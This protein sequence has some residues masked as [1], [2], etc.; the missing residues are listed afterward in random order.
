MIGI[1]CPYCGAANIEAAARDARSFICT[2]CGKAV[3]PPTRS[4]SALPGHEVVP[5]PNR[6]ASAPTPPP[7]SE[8]WSDGPPAESANRWSEVPPLGH[9]DSSP[10]LSVSQTSLLPNE[11]AEPPLVRPARSPLVWLIV[12]LLAFSAALVGVIVLARSL[13]PWL[14]A[15]HEA[16][17]RKSVEYWLPRLENGSAEERAEAAKAIVGLGPPA[18]V[19]A[20]EKVSHDPE[21]D[22]DFAFVTDAIH[23][24]AAVGPDAVF[25]L[26]AALR[27]PEPRVR[28]AAANVVQE[29]GPAG[30]AT[31]PE[32]LAARDDQNRWVC[33]AAIGRT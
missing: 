19:T 10:S 11:T 6:S 27:S 29:M 15:R 3:E 23:A 33:H 17:E 28:A 9:D 1:R 32:L 4:A 30:S 12:I 7:R 24:L 21:N 16:A 25:G 13:K 20:L 18:V 31:C 14:A 2:S 26:H 8:C 5:P 22:E